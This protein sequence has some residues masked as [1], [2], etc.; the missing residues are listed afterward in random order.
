M[1]A[2][3]PVTTNFRPAGELMPNLH[4][5]AASFVLGVAL[6]CYAGTNWMNIAL[7][8][9]S[10]FSLVNRTITWKNSPD[11]ELSENTE[12]LNEQN[13]AH[14]IDRLY[15]EITICG[16]QGDNRLVA[17]RRYMDLM[18]L[19]RLSPPGIDA[20]KRLVVISNVLLR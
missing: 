3:Q 5:P 19:A 18:R 13:L 2:I 10:L 7:T 16:L 8:G 14:A 6:N 4:L 17:Q 1:T 15:E 9:Y 11:F 12:P 20:L